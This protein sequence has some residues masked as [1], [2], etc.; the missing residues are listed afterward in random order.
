M[1]AFR[2]PSPVIEFLIQWFKIP[3][4]V[5][6]GCA[7]LLIA[8]GLL[9]LSFCTSFPSVLAAAVFGIGLGCS[10]TLLSVYTSTC[11]FFKV[12]LDKANRL[13]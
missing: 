11:F 8:A 9:A 13:R 5:Q 4:Y 3:P 6:L 12:K 7:G 1:T 10:V 2:I